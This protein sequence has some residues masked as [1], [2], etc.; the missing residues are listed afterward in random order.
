MQAPNGGRI[1]TV[2]ANEWGRY[3]AQGYEFST[4]KEYN[5]QQ[6]RGG[7]SAEKVTV[8]PVPVKKKSK[9]KKSG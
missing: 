2:P 1:R 7:E 8:K 5:E 6:A 4:E 3:R 9:K